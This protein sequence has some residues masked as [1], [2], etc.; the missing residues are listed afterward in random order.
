MAD[1]F[2]YA[3]VHVSCGSVSEAAAIGRAL[4]DER[5]V[6]CAQAT[7]ITSVYR[8][9]GEVETGEEVVLAL[10]TAAARV[11]DVAARI[12]ELHSYDLPAITWLFGGAD[13]ATAAW[14]GDATRV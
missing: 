13:P 2:E 4:V 5:L 1:E 3:E 6:A 8:W 12:A 14:I 9:D 7:P 10:K 11:P